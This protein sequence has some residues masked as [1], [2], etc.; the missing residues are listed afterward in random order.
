M[1]MVDMGATAVVFLI[2]IALVTCLHLRIWSSLSEIV[3]VIIILRIVFPMV[4][5][6][7][8]GVEKF[9]QECSQI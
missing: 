3:V 8:D 1:G 9:S 2:V 7:R 5:V 4:H 6:L